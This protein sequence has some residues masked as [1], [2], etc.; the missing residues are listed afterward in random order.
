MS[1]TPALP[2]SL[3][4]NLTIDREKV[5]DFC[6][7]WKIRELAIFGS[8][9]REDFTPASDV[10]VVVDFLP[11]AEW[12]LLDHIRMEEELA[13]ILGRQVEIITKRALEQ[14]RNRL[15]RREVERTARVLFFEVGE[16]SPARAKGR[17]DLDTLNHA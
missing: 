12:S 6:R 4:T 3:L 13:G 17:N 1:R 16:T 15:F 8:A 7:R 9:L 10:D 2:P 14:S 5:A 11:E